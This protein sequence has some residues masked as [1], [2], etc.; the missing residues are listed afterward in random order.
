VGGAACPACA[1]AAIGR[2]GRCIVALKAARL[3]VAAAVKTE[4][5]APRE[6]R[7]VE[8]SAA[9]G[10]QA[11]GPHPEQA[12]ERGSS[13]AGGAAEL[14]ARLRAPILAVIYVR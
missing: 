10:W 13:V 4:V 9:A 8:V 2:C 1:A 12:P 6:V 5:A 14:A 7:A 11:A 3:L